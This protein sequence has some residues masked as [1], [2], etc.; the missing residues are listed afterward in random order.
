MRGKRAE[1]DQEF[2]VILEERAVERL[3]AAGFERYE[4][5]NYCRPGYECR[6]NM[7]YW[8]VQACLGLGPS[9]QSCLGHARFGN[10]ANLEWY[11]DSLKKGTLPLDEMSCL[12]HDQV[13]CERVIWGLR[14][15]SG[16]S[17]RL[18]SMENHQGRALPQMIHQL[19]NEGLLRVEGQ[20]R[21][22]LTDLGIRYADTVAV[23]LL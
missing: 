7:R 4:I 22:R 15:L 13:D 21:V 16:V 6:H 23:A 18:N 14:M 19:K 9:A 5:S 1:P 2:Q 10:V 3:A 12:S 11:A 17:V 8:Q 20:E